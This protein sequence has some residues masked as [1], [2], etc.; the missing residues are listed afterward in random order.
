M[1]YRIVRQPSITL[2]LAAI[3]YALLVLPAVAPQR[4]PQ[5]SG[6]LWERIGQEMISHA[7]VIT[8]AVDPEDPDLVLAGAYHEPGLYRTTDGGQSWTVNTQGLEGLCVF[9]LQLDP[10]DRLTAYIGAT[11]GLYRST[12]GGNSWQ[13]VA[14][15]LPIAAV[16]AL[17]M[18]RTGR[19]YVG[20]EGHGLYVSMDGGRT[21]TRVGEGLAENSILSL[22]LDASGLTIVAGTGGEGLYV[23]HDG[24]LSWQQ[25]PE[26]QGSF[27][28]HVVV[29]PQGEAGFACGRDGL[30]QT[31]DGLHSW[32]RTDTGFPDRVNVV[33]FHPADSR[34]VYAATARGNLFRSDDGGRTWSQSA[35]LKKAIYTIAVHPG[36]PQRMYAGA[37]DGIY[38]SSDGGLS[39]VQ[40][41]R[42]LGTVPIEALALDKQDRQVLYAGNTFDAVYV[43]TDGGVSWAKSGD[44]LD[45]AERGYGVLSLAIPDAN[46]D[47]LYAGTDGRGV[48]VRADG[49]ET[50]SPTGPGLQ[51]GIGA[52]AVHPHDERH[53][54]IRAFF[55]RVYESTDGGV[56]WSPRWDG[57]SNEEEIVSLAI[58]TANPSTLYAGSE[59]GL[60]LTTDGA[61]S[62]NKVG[63]H[64]RTVFCVAIDPWD[65]ALVYAGTTDGLYRS[66]DGGLSWHPWG[67]EMMGITVSALALDPENPGVIYAGTKYHACWWSKD[68]GRTWL[69]ANDGL[70][71][72]SVDTLIIRPGGDIL[73]AATPDGLYRG[74]VQ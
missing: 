63:L 64:G 44:G 43:S 61:A 50:W 19:L 17:A 53:L 34:T 9:A 30:W 33:V 74:L 37:W 35:S 16:Y 59:D 25:V 65:P 24:G 13:P 1:R 40:I 5:P 15:D 27:V 38:T 36:H 26:L 12:D 46:H 55:D 54:Y 69:P 73:Y 2:L 60:Y 48:Y 11:D 56:S 14:A 68:G 29:E 49:A 4:S 39:W 3:L 52:I 67:R 71:A 21:L 7:P 62:W 41:N 28:S 23:S 45:E 66:N 22:A 8:L 6:V 31:D 32:T 51:V 72:S 42:G 47:L 57:M 70:H 10:T 58:D 18:D 20:T